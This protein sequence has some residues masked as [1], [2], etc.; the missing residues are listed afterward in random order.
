MISQRIYRRISVSSGRKPRSTVGPRQPAIFAIGGGQGDGHCQLDRRSAILL[1][2]SG[3]GYVI[4]MQTALA[5][6]EG[7]APTF[8]AGEPPKLAAEFATVKDETLA[9]TFSY[10]TATASGRKL[11]LIYSRKPE[12]YSSAAPLT[13][14]ARQRIVCELV[15]LTNSVTVS[16]SV[17]PPGTLLKAKTKDKWTA[18]NVAEQVLIDKSTARVTTGQRVSLNTVEDAKTVGKSGHTYWIYEHISQGSPNLRS[19]AQESYRHSLA[20]TTERS[21]IEEGST[22]LF[23]LNMSCPQDLWEDLEEPFKEAVDS[24]TLLDPTDAYVAPDQDP[25]RFF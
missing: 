5:E 17:G 13:A 16:L 6:E 24:F 18:K 1:S 9:Y 15:D 2:L 25:W 11:S 4:S 19:A 3:I 21:G 7:T 22:Y 10:P 14:D 12:R 8:A 23:S 20:V